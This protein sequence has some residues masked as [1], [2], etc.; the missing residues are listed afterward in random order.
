[1]WLLCCCLIVHNALTSIHSIFDLIGIH[2]L[3][4]E[5]AKIQLLSLSLFQAGQSIISGTK[6]T[7]KQPVTHTSCPNQCDLHLYSLKEKI[8]SN[9]TQYQ[10]IR[11]YLLF[12]TKSEADT[13][14]SGSHRRHSLYDTLCLVRTV[15]RWGD[16]LRNKI[17][18]RLAQY[19]DLSLK[20]SHL[21]F[22]SQ[23]H[24]PDQHEWFYPDLT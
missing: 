15:Q 12:N 2:I 7:Q 19:G 9:V 4:Y 23:M 24:F 16:S 21:C 20:K 3:Y 14:L 8:L 6:H 22:C 13:I 18:G 10:P 5:Q 11:T 1:M 17:D